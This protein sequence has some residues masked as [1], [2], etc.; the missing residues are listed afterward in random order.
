MN[1][2][3]AVA[4]WTERSIA[5]PV[6]NCWRIAA[7]V[8][9]GGMHDEAALLANCYSRSFEHAIAQG[10]KTIAFPGISTGVYGYPKEEAA[11]IALMIM[12][13]HEDSF[14][15]IIACCYSAGD[16]ALYEKLLS[17]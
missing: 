12:R 5:P 13:E 4:G 1:P 16:K 14:D 17:M 10:V 7:P 9:H 8:W 15:E 11:R 2:C 6:R 3:S